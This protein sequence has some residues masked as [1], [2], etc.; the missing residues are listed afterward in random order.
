[1][2]IS[3]SHRFIFIHIQKTA[4]QSL[5]NVLAPFCQQPPRTGWRKLLSHLPVPE[6]PR[7]VAFR[8]H[9]TARWARLKLTAPV[10]AR[11]RRFTV[12]RNPFDRAVSYYHF[13]RQNPAHH[14]HRHV[15]GLDFEGYL[16]FVHRRARSADPTQVARLCDDD[17]RLLCD[18][19]L[20]FERL[21]ADFTALCREL[22]IHD[23]PPL[24]RRN[25]SHHP[26]WPEF[27]QRGAARDLVV[28][29]FAR[30][31]DAFGY[32]TDI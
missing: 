8:P 3:H 7:R 11:Y 25:G 15:C 21:D 2:L 26:P 31:F 4:G 18:T 6:D 17:G 13:L 5:R 12:V 32:S 28:G 16:E 20:R 1:M 30:D 22:G 23:L 24:P 9:A 10:F 27:Y 19:V 14:A 29:L